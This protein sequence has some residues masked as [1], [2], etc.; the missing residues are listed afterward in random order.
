MPL[1]LGASQNVTFTIKQHYRHEQLNLRAF[2][3]RKREIRDS[4]LNL[5]ANLRKKGYQELLH[6]QFK[7]RT[8][9]IVHSY[10]Y[11]NVRLTE[12]KHANMSGPYESSSVQEA[13]RWAFNFQ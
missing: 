1:Y 5:F 10:L 2:Y 6:I 13:M 3:I 11:V 12:D 8:N 4:Y 9:Q 7:D